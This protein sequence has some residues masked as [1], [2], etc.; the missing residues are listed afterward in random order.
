MPSKLDQI[1]S[2]LDHLKLLTNAQWIGEALREVDFESL[3]LGDRLKG[4][5]YKKLLERIES[6]KNQTREG[7]WLDE[8]QC[9]TLAVEIAQVRDACIGW[10]SVHTP[11]VV[12]KEAA[13][14]PD[15][16]TKRFKSVSRAAEAL[17]IAEKV[18]A[19]AKVDLILCADLA[20][21]LTQVRLD[22]QSLPP[23][24]KWGPSCPGMATADEVE[25]ALDGFGERL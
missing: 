2:W 5:D 19:R 4:T 17:E 7:V 12:E 3:G 22:L 23:V 8:E 21:D 10:V 13:G 20:R 6:V 16:E 14:K 24:A 1:Q 15:S 18:A 9:E 25:A 11:S